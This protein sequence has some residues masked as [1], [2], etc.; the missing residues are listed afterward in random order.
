MTKIFHP[1][2]DD[3]PRTFSESMTINNYLLW[4]VL[5][6]RY[7]LFLVVYYELA[8]KKNKAFLHL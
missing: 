3:S 8:V 1:A 5:T 2:S 7:Q 4:T 6:T